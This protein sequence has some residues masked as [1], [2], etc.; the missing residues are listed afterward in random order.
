MPTF[1]FWYAVFL[2]GGAVGATAGAT[3]DNGPALLAGLLGGMALSGWLAQQLASNPASSSPDLETPSG[4]TQ[5]SAQGPDT[6]S[7]HPVLQEP[8]I[9]ALPD[10]FGWPSLPKGM[11]AGS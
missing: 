11:I 5:Q 9:I 4:E 8:A 7:T 2:F 1:A 10:T 6:A 3:F